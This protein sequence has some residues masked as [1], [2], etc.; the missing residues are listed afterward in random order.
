MKRLRRERSDGPHRVE[1]PEQKRAAGLGT[2]PGE[3][4]VAASLED[5]PPA[6][7][8]YAERRARTHSDSAVTAAASADGLSLVTSASRSPIIE[9]ALAE[10][11]ARSPAVSGVSVTWRA[12]AS[13]A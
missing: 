6:G 11:Y 3:H 2:E 10:K 7:T 8:P 4:A 13:R 1:V 12:P 5:D 9:P